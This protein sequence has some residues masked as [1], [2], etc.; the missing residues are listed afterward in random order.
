MKLRTRQQA[1]DLAERTGAGHVPPSDEMPAFEVLHQR[2]GRRQA[3]EV[4]GVE[5]ASQPG[6][7]R[8]LLDV[9]R[10]RGIHRRHRKFGI[11]E[12]LDY[13][14]KRFPNLTRETEAWSIVS[15]L[16][17]DP[18]NNLTKDGIDN[19]VGGLQSAWE[20]VDE[21]DLQ[22]FELLGQPLP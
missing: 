12:R 10:R 11:L 13:G 17:S 3:D 9:P 19:V 15:T 18:A 14:W 16:P 1:S 7:G 22:V 4:L 6:L 2:L 21:R 20:I 5:G 8:T